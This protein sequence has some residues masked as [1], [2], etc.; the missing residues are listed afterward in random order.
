MTLQ[1]ELMKAILAMDAYNRGYDASITL[2]S[3]IG[4]QIGNASITTTSTIALGDGVDSA[5]GF[6]ALA[7]DTNGDGTA[8]VISYRGTDYPQNDT[9]PAKDIYHGWSLGAGITASEQGQIAV[10]FYQAIV[11]EGNW[12]TANISLT[13][14]S[15]G[16]G[17]AGF[18]GALYD[19]NATVY[20]SMT[21]KAAANKAFYDS[22]HYD[23][24]YSTDNG[25][26]YEQDVVSYTQLQDYLNDPDVDVQLYALIDAALKQKIYGDLTVP[27]I[28]ALG[29]DYVGLVGYYVNG[30]AL[31]VMLPLRDGSEA[32]LNPLHELDGIDLIP[33]INPFDEWVARHSQASLVITMFKDEVPTLTDWSAASQ[34][35]WPV[36]YDDSFAEQVVDGAPNIAGELLAQGKYA[37]ILRMTI[38]YSAL[39]EGEMPFGDTGIR[40]FYHDAN[41]LGKALSN[42][43]VSDTLTTHAKDI[44][45]AFVE[46][47]GTLA[48]NDIEM[49]SPS[50]VILDGVLTL[51]EEMN[52]HTLTID[53]D[54]VLWEIAGNGVLPSMVARE[55]LAGSLLDEIDPTSAARIVMGNIWGN[56]TTDAFERVIFSTREG[57]TTDIQENLNTVGKAT[58]FIGGDGANHVT[59]TSGNDLLF[60]GN[61]VDR[62]YGSTGNDIL[63][64]GSASDQYIFDLSTVSGVVNI[65]DADSIGLDSLTIKGF[66]YGNDH[67]VRGVVGTDSFDIIFSEG[68]RDALE[69]FIVDNDILTIRIDK[70][71]VLN[72]TSGVELLSLEKLGG[73]DKI[74]M[75]DFIS[76]DW[77]ALSAPV[78]LAYTMH[79]VSGVSFV[80]DG[81]GGEVITYADGGATAIVDE[82]GNTTGMVV[83]PLVGGWYVDRAF[84]N[85]IV[86]PFI[87]TGFSIETRTDEFGNY[88]GSNGSLQYE[89]YIKEVAFLPGLTPDDV[90]FTLGGIAGDSSL[91]IH[92]DSMNYSTTIDD[93]EAGRLIY[94]A[95]FDGS[96]LQE[97]VGGSDISASLSS[98][99]AGSYNG[100]YQSTSPYSIN[101]DNQSVT[102]FLET[103]SFAD[104]TVID[105]LGDITFTGSAGGETLQ[106]MDAHNDTIRGM[107]GDDYLWGYDGNDTL[108]G[109]TGNDDLYGGAGDDAYLFAVGDGTGI[110][111]EELNEGIDTVYLAE[112]ILPEDVLVWNNGLGRYYLQYSSDP[113]DVIQILA[114]NDATGSLVSSYV[115][116]IVFDNGT[117][118][119]LSQG[120]ILNGVDVGQNLYGSSAA[121]TIS[122]NGGDDILWG[123]D[124]NDTLIGGAGNDDLYGGAGD[125]AY[126]FAVGDGT[127]IIHEEL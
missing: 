84:A 47:A 111:H 114:G 118:W 90:R 56:D 92:I 42:S 36:M 7:Y 22:T 69:N 112:G 34:Y 39:D 6:Y 59:G 81:A 2:P 38:A 16:G 5:I 127:G 1:P 83:Q 35:F 109:G 103:V 95:Y 55:D 9:T 4:D 66:G 104:G 8:N 76:V 94:G 75:D 101:D 68:H 49:S 91:T 124:G 52:N 20:D 33:G 71:G 43:V 61:G 12:R 32:E 11:G 18:V 117:V 121:D 74:H 30:E 115:E 119:D 96:R 14:H 80:D 51:A 19:K 97:V 25:V 70:T 107:G 24:V 15:L 65:V 102:Y 89:T 54:E 85:E 63:M 113:A 126:L 17:L 53:F 58:L 23:I 67:S 86:H 123:Y 40:A 27:E 116:N 10:E 26:T 88:L 82:F 106:G 77:A 45:K 60:G 108:I 3:S 64:G 100:V 93:Y 120:L 41:E 78:T 110:I 31:D 48:L 99:Q 21:Y 62:L 13:G 29:P 105:M 125:D 79:T 57:G 122:G 87:L 44:S 50:D 72:G 46:F 73:T 98:T 37:D 28:E